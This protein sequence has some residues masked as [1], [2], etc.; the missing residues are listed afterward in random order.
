MKYLLLLAVVLLGAWVWRSGR[1]AGQQQ[2]KPASRP[3]A[4][5]QDM[6]RCQLCSVH[7]PKTDAVPG[8]LGIYCSDEHRQ[9]VE[10]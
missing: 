4:E 1:L 3:A 5:P 10:P 9:R 8:K 7:L 6:V 2:K